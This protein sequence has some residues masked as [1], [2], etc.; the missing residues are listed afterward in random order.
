M[1]KGFVKKLMNPKTKDYNLLKQ[2]SLGGNMTWRYV[3]ST[4]PSINLDTDRYT[5]NGL[6]QHTIVSGPDYPPY[7]LVPRVES[8]YAD[9]VFLV[10]KQILDYNNIEYTQI[11]RCV[12][13]QIHYWD[14]KP[15]PPHLD[16]YKIPHNN[17]LVYLNSFDRG[18]IDVYTEDG[19]FD[20]RFDHHYNDQIDHIESYK[21]FEDDIIIFGGYNHSVHQ[22][23]PMQR[24]VVLVF[25]YS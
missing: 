1:T 19:D 22:P 17:C 11:H 23:A 13:N 15:S 3:N 9:L 21:P 14:G 18:E 7:S 2:E 4:D 16:H 12:I 10:I 6:Y 24:R 8:P 25:T 20:S 5:A